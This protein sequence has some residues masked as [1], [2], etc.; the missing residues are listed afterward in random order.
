MNRELTQ[1]HPFVWR[2]IANNPSVMTGP[3]TNTYLVGRDSLTVIDPGPFDKSHVTNTVAAAKSLEKPIQQ[4]IVTHHHPDHDGA[5]DLLVR[6]LGISWWDFGNPLK[7]EEVVDAGGVSLVVKHT[8]GHIYSHISLW[9][10]EQR[11]LFA[12]DLVA[13]QGTILI[14][15]PDGDMADYF[16]SLAAMK[17]LDAVAIL[18]GHG[19]VLENPTEL[20]QEYIDHR[21]MR[22]EQVLT[23]FKQGYKMAQD[24]ASQIYGDRGPEVLGIATLQIEAH[25]KKLAEERRI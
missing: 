11:L 19:P 23:L 9:Q 2:L 8:P 3:G 14:I 21:L 24:L 15:P 20:L 16:N 5:A 7:A 1:T 13:G 10:P 4:I 25:L 6:E 12:G 18:P 17:L 22:E